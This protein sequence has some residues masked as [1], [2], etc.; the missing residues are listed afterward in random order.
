M[1][2]TD[3]MSAF[4][5]NDTL[6]GLDI[7]EVDITDAGQC[8][9]RIPSLRPDAIIN[10]AALTAVDYCE[11][12]ADE[13]FRVNGQGAG[14]VAA[15]AASVKALLVHYSTDYVFDGL[16]QEPYQ[17]EDPPAPRSIYG[18]SKLRGEELIR[19]ACPDHLILRTAWLFGSTGKNFIGTILAA[20]RS[21]Q[22][23]RVVADQRGSPTYTR[24]LADC[25][26]RMVQAGCRGLYHVTNSGACTWHEL[27]V[28]AV[29]WASIPRTSILPVS[30][31]EYPLPA[32]RPA[33]SVL[34]NTR[35]VRDGLPP[36]RPLQEAV[37]EYIREM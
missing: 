7:S 36:L 35:L 30:S 8:H 11:S 19:A 4:S 13:A 25:T 3:L 5:G 6:W 17:E 32:P 24:D 12:H 34:A 29:E 27:A 16:K 26:V 2:G 14:N 28:R 21:G 31:Q 20:A 37:Q 9:E 33:N 18:Q 10:A 15:V 1:L 23:L 22:A